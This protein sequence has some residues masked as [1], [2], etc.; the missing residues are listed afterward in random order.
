MAKETVSCECGKIIPVEDGY[1][2]EDG[3]WNCI[4][5]VRAMSEEEPDPGDIF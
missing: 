3:T 4:E 5:C 2:D 1:I